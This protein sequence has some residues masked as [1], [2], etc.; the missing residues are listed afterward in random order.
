MN[1]PNTRLEESPVGNDPP[2]P[3]LSGGGY[4]KLRRTVVAA[5]AAVSLIPLIILALANY[6]QYQR[7]FLAEYV[8]SVLQLTTNNKR[9]LEFF[10]AERRSAMSYLKLEYSF[11]DLCSPGALAKII[12]NLNRSFA[13]GAFFDLG[14]VDSKGTQVCYHGPYDL[15]GKE[16]SDQ[17]W[18]HRVSRRGTFTSDVFLGHRKSPHF[19]IAHRHDMANGDFYILRATVEAEM[20]S[21]Q[22]QTEGLPPN[23]DVFLVNNGSVLQTRSKRYGGVL[24]Q[25]PLSIAECKRDAAVFEKKD[26]HGKALFLGCAAVEGSPFTLVFLK[27]FHTGMESWLSLRARLFAFLAISASLILV[28]IFWGSGQFVSNIRAANLR[29]A[30]LMHHMEYQNKL[31]SIG[32]LA[33]GVA[34]EINNPLAIINE[35]GGLLKDLITLQED[36]P[37]RDKSLKV[38]DSILYSVERCK[39]ITHRLLGFAKHMDLQSEQINIPA[40]VKEVVNFLEKEAE[41]RKVEISIDAA[42]YVPAIQSDRGQLQQV[43]LNIINN[44]L[45]AV[46]EGGKVE[47]EISIKENKVIAVEIADNGVGIPPE[48]L[49]RIFEPFFT[50]KKGSGTGLG[51]SITYGII[52]KLGGDVVVE[53]QV[54]EGTR[55]TVYLPFLTER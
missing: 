41:Y 30:A 13:I 24:K 44:A 48:N 42:P 20:L 25:L 29:R 21:E 32:R 10:L 2:R 3:L 26:E 35:K 15:L 49:H 23:D 16:Y 34:H 8:Q 37:N 31:A 54:G 33:A 43:F 6:L 22:L 18:F 39:R 4:Y 52:K 1:E 40:L 9:S 7:S 55:F 28:V 17:D 36:F 53:S 46:G 38:I 19:V 50:T 51:L 14:I 5:T 12:V 45:A 11:Q 27:S 47:I